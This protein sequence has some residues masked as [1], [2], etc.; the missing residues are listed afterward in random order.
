MFSGPLNSTRFPSR[1]SGWQHW[2]S[3]AFMRADALF[4]LGTATIRPLR[5]KV[6]AKEFL[7]AEKSM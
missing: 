6:L 1:G 3:A 2:A 5:P 4:V 7:C